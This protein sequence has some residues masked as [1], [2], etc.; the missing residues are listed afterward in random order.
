[1]SRFAKEDKVFG[2]NDTLTADELKPLVQPIVES[3]KLAEVFFPRFEGCPENKRTGYKKVL[4][5][6][7]D[8]SP[9]MTGSN[10]YILDV[11]TEHWQQYVDKMAAGEHIMNPAFN[12]VRV[13]CL[14]YTSPSPRD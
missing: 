3:L 1:M 12:G 11:P 13:P 9:V 2:W 14:L 10:A 6:Q 7:S 5:G 8:A 4:V